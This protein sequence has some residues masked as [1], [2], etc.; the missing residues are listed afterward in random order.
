M[1][2]KKYPKVIQEFIDTQRLY[3]NAVVLTE[4]GSFFEIWE[5]EELKLGHAIRVSQILDI[6]LTRRDKSDPTSP[7]MAGFPNYT[8]ENYIKKLVDAG[9]TVVVVKQEVSGTKSDQ[10]KNVKRVIER[11]IS[12]ATSLS[13]VKESKSQYF[14][15][16]YQEDLFVGVCLIDLSTGEV[17]ISE[18]D[19]EQSKVFI[20]NNNPL[21]ILFCQEAFIEK[22]DKQIFH[23]TKKNIDRQSS[24]GVV[25]SHVY[26]ESNPSSN[27]SVILSKIGINLWRLGSLALA[28][29]LDFLV[30]YNPL[31]L[32]K[33]SKPKIDQP[34]DYLFLSKNAYPSLELIQSQN[35][36]DSKKTLL[37]VMDN[38]KTA[39]GRRVLIQFI[40]QPLANLEKINERHE[41]V[42]S[43]IDKNDYLIE[44]KEVFDIARLSRRLVLKNLMPHEI[45]NLYKSLKIS[46][47]SLAKFN[48]AQKSIKQVIKFIES[49]IDFDILEKEGS[50]DFNFYRG[51]LKSKIES[52]RKEWDEAHLK[53]VKKTEQISSILETDK[54]RIAERQESIQIVIPKGVYKKFISQKIKHSFEFKEKAS[55]IQVIDKDWEEI[56]NKE[57]YL[58]RKFNLVAE[59]AWEDFQFQIIEKYGDSLYQ[60]SEEVGF[61]DTLST[62]AQIAN[63]RNY[64]R[65]KFIES[66]SAFVKISKMRH[67]VVEVSKDLSESFVPNDLH[68]DQL[69]NTLVIY[70][71]NS[72]GKSTILKSLAVNIIMAQM[73]SFVPAESMEMSVFDSIMTRMTTYDSLSEGLSTFT[74]EMIELQNALK[75]K[76]KKSLFV[77]DE[78][79]RGTSPEDGEAIAFACLD[80]LKDPSNNSITLFSTHYHSLYENIKNFSNIEIT[81][82]ACELR[83]NSL[84]FSRKL[85]PGPGMGS[86][87]LLV[88]ESCGLPE[89]IIRLAENY[90]SKHHKLIVSRY[91][92]SIQS[93][94]C[95]LCGQ[96][97]ANETHHLIE[98]HQGKVESINLNG[99]KKSVHDK[100]NL[101]LICSNC[102]TKITQNKIKI[103][104]RKVINNGSSQFVLDIEDPSQNDTK[105]D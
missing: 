24:A 15:C 45:L 46:D 11:I 90:R 100:G 29:L 74:M 81:H 28:N 66:K 43:F 88:A 56:A 41:L 13:S 42:Q 10:N 34:S 63:E 2:E 70:G 12:P 19:L 78:I 69:K 82:M 8:A 97:Q 5:L 84:I 68:L 75:K 73:G 14:A 102:H 9:E 22:K 72:A 91:N 21:E 49:R 35:D 37:G 1:T 3:P 54:L 36:L 83:E 50:L 79:G 52:E 64:T 26:E 93:N 76:S 96:A 60:F 104:K 59:K 92:S 67:P 47:K 16:C 40:Q 85:Q 57:F 51:D 86:Y 89:S 95:E 31:L 55:E 61:I 99:V 101:V 32:K 33:I 38:C 48:R 103:N 25:L 65:P 20:E 44:L 53:L 105:K 7:R 58:K 87:G 98:Q 17:R 80:F 27:H 39:M 62:F 18:M 30:E 6:A 94:Q 77:F 4:V 23:L 71:A